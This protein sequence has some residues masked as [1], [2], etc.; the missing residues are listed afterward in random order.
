MNLSGSE[1]AAY[2]IL[3]LDEDQ[4][5]AL[6]GRMQDEE[7]Q[8]LHAVAQGLSTARVAPYVL[9]GIYAEFVKGVTGEVPMLWGGSGYL[10][11]LLRRAIGEERAAPILRAPPPPSG[12]LDDVASD[13]KV[14]AEMLSQE[15]PQ[16]ISAVLSQVEPSVASVVL[17]SL[18]EEV[19][20]QVIDRM[21][22]LSSISPSAIHATRDTLST[23]L[24]ESLSGAEATP[25][26]SRAAAILNE[27]LPEHSASILAR[28]ESRAPDR[29]AAIRREQFT[30][31]DLAKL[32]R[33][34]MQTLLR[35]VDASQL[36]M[37]LKSASERLRERVFTSMSSRA[38]ETLKEDLQNLG[39]QRV[40]DVEKAQWDIVMSA[41]RLAGEGKLTLITGGQVV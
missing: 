1:K 29:A 5:T 33:R 4:A 40:A 6:L 9:H 39:P 28:I 34:G 37:A 41:V 17:A 27:M 24:G 18:P 2:F 15:H 3:S 23:E 7:L 12:P 35:E 31:E 19:Q 13:G 32:D 20:E 14:L 8:R 21:A 22:S 10:A 11:Q 38:A 25:G 16:A 36:V 26:A 30:F